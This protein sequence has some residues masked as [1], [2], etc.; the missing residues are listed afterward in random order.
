MMMVMVEKFKSEG[1]PCCVSE[2]ALGRFFGDGGNENV[3][4]LCCVM[5]VRHLSSWLLSCFDTPYFLQM[6]KLGSS[7]LS[8]SMLVG[9]VIY[10]LFAKGLSLNVMMI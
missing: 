1:E 3:M 7:H 9:D 10:K 2:C 8:S 5:K 4:N 6:H